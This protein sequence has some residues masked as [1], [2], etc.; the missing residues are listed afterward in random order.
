MNGKSK[1]NSYHQHLKRTGKQ[2]ICS[3][4]VHGIFLPLFSSSMVEEHQ[5]YIEQLQETLFEKDNE[6]H[7]LSQRLNA[8]ELELEKTIDDHVSKS[9][10][11]E[12][13]LQSLTDERNALIEQQAM[14]LEE[15]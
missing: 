3:D 10:K 6:K 2:Y 5:K 4:D 14:H 1:W 12:Q 7:S 11:Y 8:L 9:N 13:S 15:W